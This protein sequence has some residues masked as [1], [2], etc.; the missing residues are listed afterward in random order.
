[1]DIQMKI[2]E[3]TQDKAILREVSM[4][5]FPSMIPYSTFKRAVDLG[6]HIGGWSAL[7]K[8][9]APDCQIVAF[10][11]NASNL[12]LL[13][14]NMDQFEGV[15]VVPTRV[16]YAWQRVAIHLPKNGNTGGTGYVPDAEGEI[17]D[18]TRLPPYL[19]DEGDIDCLKIDIEGGEFDVLMNA[20]L[21]T[22]A[23]FRNIVGEYHGA[24]GDPD[25]IFHRLDDDFRLTGLI[26]TSADLG[27]FWLKRR[28]Q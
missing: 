15:T 21:F 20:P 17:I 7:V 14:L 26:P 24:S 1:M 22:L 19:W 6:A 3:G 9:Y 2:R 25:H 23:R 4:C 18:S 13:Y 8:L 28:D 5:Y 12:E 11:P 10:E 27:V 16:A